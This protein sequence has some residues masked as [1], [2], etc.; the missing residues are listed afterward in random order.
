M[1]IHAAF[2]DLKR[3][4]TV[5][6]RLKIKRYLDTVRTLGRRYLKN[7]DGTETIKAQNRYLNC[8]RSVN[9]IINVNK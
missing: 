2:N 7:M 5:K 9:I 6:K 1:F 8:T 4:R 3:F